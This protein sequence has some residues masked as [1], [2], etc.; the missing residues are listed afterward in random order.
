MTRNRNL[1]LTLLIVALAGVGL[2][3][4]G[5]VVSAGVLHAVWALWGALLGGTL[6]L[7]FSRSSGKA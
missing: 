3:S 5:N 2:L 4:A 1:L 7:M 6:A